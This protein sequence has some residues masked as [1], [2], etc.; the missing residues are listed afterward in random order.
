MECEVVGSNPPLMPSYVLT[1]A[2]I[3][4]VMLIL[5]VIITPWPPH[6]CG[7]CCKPNCSGMDCGKTHMSAATALNIEQAA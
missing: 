3:P 5:P 4:N 6:C 7:M 2:T 1:Y